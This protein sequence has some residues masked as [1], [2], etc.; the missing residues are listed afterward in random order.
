[1]VVRERA[2]KLEIFLFYG[3]GIWGFWDGEE[4][5]EMEVCITEV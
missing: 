2:V 5:D 4:E 1:V 3:F